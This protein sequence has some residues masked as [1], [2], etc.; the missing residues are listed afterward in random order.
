MALKSP[1]KSLKPLKDGPV[2]IPVDRFLTY[3]LLRI[4]NRLTR[5]GMSLAEEHAGLRLPEWRCLAF[6]GASGGMTLHAVAEMTAMDRGLITRAVQGLAR[7]RLVLLARQADDRRVVHA[8]PTTQGLDLYRRVLPR[9]Q[10]RQ[11][12]LLSYLSESDQRAAYRI[13]D[14]LNQCLDEWPEG[15]LR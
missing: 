5:Q 7:K 1:A 11:T 3:R 14:R 9:M 12:R 6:I 4:S 15:A 13:L 2:E 8:R 10:A